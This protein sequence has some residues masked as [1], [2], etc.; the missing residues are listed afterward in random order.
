MKKSII[1]SL[2]I[3]MAA[4]Y[5]CDPIENRDSNDL[6]IGADELEVSATPVVV[7]GVNS[8]KVVLKNMSPVNSEWNYGI[9]ITRKSVDTVLMVVTG[10]STIS[11]TGLNPDGSYVTKDI[12]VTVDELTFPV[13]PQWGLLCGSGS[14]TWVWDE[15]ASSVWGNGGYLG[16]TAPC[17]WTNDKASMDSNDPDFGSN[18]SLT[19]SIS[20]ASLVKSNESGSNQVSG[21]FSFDMSKTTDDGNGGLWAVGKLNTK[22]VTV[23]AGKAPNNG[24]APIYEYDIL[25]LDEDKLYLGWPEPGQGAWGTAWFWMYRAQ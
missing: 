24:D 17:W 14:K 6:P 18:G 13:P 8:N 23:L 25:Q 3:L 22:N 21:S 20:G 12:S 5:A 9:G 16:C 15:T 4:F 19:F 11:F 7:N 10:P 1:Y 2:I